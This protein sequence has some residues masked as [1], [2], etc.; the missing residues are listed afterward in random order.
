M[1]GTIRT[2]SKI[3]TSPAKC[4]RSRNAMRS[5]SGVHGVR[6][7]LEIDAARLSGHG[8]MKST[9]SDVWLRCAIAS[10]S[11][12]GNHQGLTLERRSR[13]PNRI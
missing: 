9:F 6:R 7:R 8:H 1:V 5:A 3:I 12:Y 11:A 10:S 13:S 2:K 4:R